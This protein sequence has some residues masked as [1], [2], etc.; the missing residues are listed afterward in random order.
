MEADL[1][2]GD[3]LRA[4]E[5]E[6]SGERLINEQY[7]SQKIIFN[8][9]ILYSSTNDFK[10]KSTID[11]VLHR[12]TTPGK[13]RQS[14]AAHTV[15]SLANS[16]IIGSESDGFENITKNPLVSTNQKKQSNSI[17]NDTPRSISSASAHSS[18]SS[19]FDLN[20]QS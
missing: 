5:K 12:P 13:L 8:N 11:P 16:L 2:L 18:T 20:T 19:T 10:S 9:N 1:D 15:D 4:S 17:T 3:K 7:A 6:L 14:H